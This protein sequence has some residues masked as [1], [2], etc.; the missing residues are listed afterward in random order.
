MVLSFTWCLAQA[1]NFAKELGIPSSQKK[2][3]DRKGEKNKGQASLP[4]SCQAPGEGCTRWQPLFNLHA[5][6]QHDERREDRGWIF[7]IY[8]AMHPCTNW[9]QQAL[10]SPS[11]EAACAAV[12]AVLTH[13]RLKLYLRRARR[14]TGGAKAGIQRARRKFCTSSSPGGGTS[15]SPSK[16]RLA[17]QVCAST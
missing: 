2:D 12:H 11:R 6:P 15:H 17:R 3:R 9:C 16:L 4:I 13:P 14:D 10:A 7:C 1:L 5:F 8:A